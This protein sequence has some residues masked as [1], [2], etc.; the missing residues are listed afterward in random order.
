MAIGVDAA[1]VERIRLGACAIGC[2]ERSVATDAFWRRGGGVASLSYRADFSAVVVF[3]L[4]NAAHLV[5]RIVDADAFVGCNELALGG[6]RTF[7]RAIG[8]R[9]RTFAEH[10]GGIALHALRRNANGDIFAT[11]GGGE[12]SGC[13]EEWEQRTSISHENSM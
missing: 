6:R 1:I 11:S 12:G 3:A 13:D 2:F 9:A 8:D 7:E 10:R 5:G 4:G